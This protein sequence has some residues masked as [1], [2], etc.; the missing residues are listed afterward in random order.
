MARKQ[1]ESRAFR[2]GLEAYLG[3]VGWTGLDFREGFK[4][5]KTIV[6]PGVAIRFLP[7]N[8]KSLQLGGRGNE[9]LNKRVIQ[10]DCYMESEDRANAITD[11]CMDFLDFEPVYIKDPTDQVIGTL[12]CQD[13]ESIYAEVLPPILPDPRIK[14]WR[15][16]VRAT[17]EAHYFGS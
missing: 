12:I 17:L 15:G 14:R 9:D 8:K 6:V 4:S 16:V 2:L 7:S 11:D 1:Y 13:T 3:L 5:D 10:I